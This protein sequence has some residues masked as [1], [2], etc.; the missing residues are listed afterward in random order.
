[1]RITAHVVRALTRIRD[2]RLVWD[3]MGSMYNRRIVESVDGLVDR[4]G[5][6]V[7]LPS[8]GRLLDVGCGRGDDALHL[9]RDNPD[10]EVTGID[11]SPVQVRA[12][13]RLQRQT[14]ISNCHFERANVM[15][16]PFVEQTFD[17]AVSIGSVKHW[18]DAVRGLG[19]IRRVLKPDGILIVSDTD[20]RAS[21]DDIRLFMSRFRVWFVPDRVFFWG[22]RRVIF[23]QSFT[24]QSLADAISEAGFTHIESARLAD[25]PYVIA[26]A[27]KQDVV[28]GGCWRS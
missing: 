24:Q 2:A 3:V 7:H 28:E 18:P 16:L 6:E 27:T 26:K 10:A 17:V 11:F 4:V 1:M 20:R 14:G 21:D 22:L 15:N 19:E 23:G 8:G 12:A 9:A 5:S 25:P 13:R